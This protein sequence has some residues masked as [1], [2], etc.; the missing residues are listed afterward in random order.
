VLGFID[1]SQ[2]VTSQLKTFI[3]VGIAII[4]VVVVKK[5][6]ESISIPT[7]YI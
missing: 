5:I 1:P 2:S 6:L 4:I 3:P 7:V